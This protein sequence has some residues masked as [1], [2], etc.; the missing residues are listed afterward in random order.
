[1]NALYRYSIGT[2]DIEKTLM[3][4][5]ASFVVF[6]GFEIAG[7][8]QRMRGVAVQNLDTLFKVKNIQALPEGSQLCRAVRYF[9][10]P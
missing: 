3:L 2:I 10:Y 5:V 6:G 9:P 8:M 4:I 1:M 7:T